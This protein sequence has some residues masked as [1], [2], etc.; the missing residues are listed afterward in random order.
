[1]ENIASDQSLPSSER[2]AARTQADQLWSEVDRLMR[3]IDDINNELSALYNELNAL[4]DECRSK[5]CPDCGQT[6]TLSDPLIL[7]KNG[8]TTP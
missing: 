1:M 8:K 5:N 4:K 3:D 2:A 6:V 7:L